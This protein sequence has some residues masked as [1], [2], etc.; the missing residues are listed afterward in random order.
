MAAH[1]VVMVTGCDKVHSTRDQDGG[2]RLR[3]I[4]QGE[5]GR[6]FTFLVSKQE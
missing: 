2:V 6:E 5:K 1:E 3:G 4:Q